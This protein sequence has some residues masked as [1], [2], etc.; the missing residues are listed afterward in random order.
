MHDTGE[1]D[2]RPRADN[3]RGEQMEAGEGD[4]APEEMLGGWQRVFRPEE[5]HDDP[6]VIEDDAQNSGREGEHEPMPRPPPASG[7]GAPRAALG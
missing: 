7:I 3:E 6:P 1:K 2:E 5:E 4:G